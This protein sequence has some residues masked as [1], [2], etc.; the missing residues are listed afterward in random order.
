MC[1]AEETRGV[2]E[3][4]QALRA[5]RGRASHSSREGAPECSKYRSAGRVLGCSGMSLAGSLGTGVYAQQFKPRYL[6]RSGHIQVRGSSGL[7]PG[8]G[9]EG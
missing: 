4:G 3:M 7:G 1:E 8:G 5:G 2:G 6:S 9:R